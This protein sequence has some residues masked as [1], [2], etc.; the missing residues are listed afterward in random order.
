MQHSA[1]PKCS[2]KCKE[3]TSS[4]RMLI[5][6]E[7]KHNNHEVHKFS[8]M[9]QKQENTIYNLTV[10]RHEKSQGMIT[11]NSTIWASL[12]CTWAKSRTTNK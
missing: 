9:K 2:K 8:R 5:R 7:I 11:C 10:S 1:K 3:S 12:Y 6:Y 4:R